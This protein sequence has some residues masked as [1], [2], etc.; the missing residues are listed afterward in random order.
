MSVDKVTREG[1]QDPLTFDLTQDDEPYEIGANFF[2]FVLADKNNK[3]VAQWNRLTDPNRFT[4]TPEGHPSRI[5]VHPLVDTFRSE[6]SKYKAFFWIKDGSDNL[7]NPSTGFYTI[8]VVS[9]L[10]ILP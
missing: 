8:E 10:G 4:I 3:I 9:N 6:L 5:I 1:S 7:S 2:K